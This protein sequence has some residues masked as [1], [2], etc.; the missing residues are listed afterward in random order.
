MGGSEEN[1]R[2][3]FTKRNPS[4]PTSKGLHKAGGTRGE[5]S[6]QPIEFDSQG[7]LGMSWERR[8]CYHPWV[9]Y[10]DLECESKSI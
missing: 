1:T 6:H 2:Y 3:A 9:T 4:R 10:G 8:D 5:T 7:T